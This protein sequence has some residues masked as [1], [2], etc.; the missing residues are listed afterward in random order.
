M[1]EYQASS[2]LIINEQRWAVRV[3][4][5]EYPDVDDG[6]QIAYAAVTGS[7]GEAF[8]YI[9]KFTKHIMRNHKYLLSHRDDRVKHTILKTKSFIKRA[10]FKNLVITIAPKGTDVQ[11]AE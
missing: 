3:E 4:Y 7:N 5:D 2:E 9:F 8:E 11:I 6:S 10:N 1:R